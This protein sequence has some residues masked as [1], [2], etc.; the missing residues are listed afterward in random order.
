MSNFSII[1]TVKWLNNLNWYGKEKWYGEKQSVLEI[2][3]INEGYVKQVDNLI[4]YTILR[5]GHS[6]SLILSL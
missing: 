1:G 4:F 2:D 6:V 5:A 3:T